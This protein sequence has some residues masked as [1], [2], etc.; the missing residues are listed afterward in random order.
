MKL[1]CITLLLVATLSSHAQNPGQ[2]H[3]TYSQKY[4][5]GMRYGFFA[6]VNYNKSNSYPLIVY[7]HGSRDTVSRDSNYYSEAFQSQHPAFMITPKCTDP[8]LGWG[9]TWHDQHT[10]HAAKV[11]KLIDSLASHLSIDKKRIYI[12]GIS[13][14]GFGVFSML[15]KEPGKFAAAYAICGGSDTKAAP[16]LLNTP[17]WIFHGTDDD[18]V[19]VYLSR[20]IYK[21]ILKL[22]GKLVKYTEYPGVKHNSWE[23]ALREKGLNDWLFSYPAQ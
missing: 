12:Y 7:L 20:D 16:K 14:G 19:P 11:V 9:D 4:F 2:K 15:A 3:K 22:G 18:I 8:N 6:P 10:P 13:M 21:E 5:Q 17:L 23:N 1:F